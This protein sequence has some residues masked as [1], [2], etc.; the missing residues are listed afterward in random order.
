[1]IVV[2]SHERDDHAHEV[3]AALARMGR[4]GELVDTAAY[5]RSASIT[6]H[7][8]S[9]G[10]S[11]TVSSGRRR[12]DL[13]TA[14]AVWWRR[15]QS[16]TLHDGIDPDVAGFAYSE[17]HEAVSGL[18][19][20]LDTS[21]VNPPALDE[22]AHH[23]PYQLKVAGEVGLPVPRTVITNDPG[24]ARAFAAELGPGRTVYK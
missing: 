6:Q 21:W 2:V 16:F 24:A 23:K 11:A 18:W 5:P 4:G 12:I 7:F 19:A 8:G 3:L 13:T 20:S 15:P 22:A 10:T 14:G 17:C 9:Q 1:M